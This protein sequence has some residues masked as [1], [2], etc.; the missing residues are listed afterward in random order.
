MISEF[1]KRKTWYE[2]ERVLPNCQ[3]VS[4]WAKISCRPALDGSKTKRF[5]RESRWSGNRQGFLIPSAGSVWLPA[6]GHQ[7]RSSTMG[8]PTWAQLQRLGGD[9][10]FEDPPPSNT[11]VQTASCMVYGGSGMGSRIILGRR[12]NKKPCASLHARHSLTLKATL[13]Q[14]RLLACANTP[15]HPGP[16]VFVRW[17]TLCVRVRQILALCG[18]PQ[19]EVKY[20][21][22][23]VFPRSR[24]RFTRKAGSKSRRGS[25]WTRDR[26][27]ARWCT[28]W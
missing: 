6:G 15:K 11:V 24:L 19:P 23:C 17:C 18:K 25:G 2:N 3:D 10:G 8:F 22:P 7:R 5:I 26:A 4:H 1:S 28:S 27:S 12:R 16:S 13:R 14:S 21:K 20:E 9:A